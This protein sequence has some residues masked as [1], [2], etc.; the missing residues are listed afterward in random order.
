MMIIWER[1]D[2]PPDCVLTS[3]VTKPKDPKDLR[4]SHYFYSKVEERITHKTC[5][6]CSQSAGHFVWLDIEEFSYRAMEDGS[7]KPQPQCGQCR[8]TRK[9]N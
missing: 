9:L 3:K 1:E 4:R 7:F 5:T 2:F 8:G 6:K